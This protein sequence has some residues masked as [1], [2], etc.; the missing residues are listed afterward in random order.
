MMVAS[1]PPTRRPA[2][3]SERKTRSWAGEGEDRRFP[4]HRHFRPRASVR[5]LCR[6]QTA[7]KQTASRSRS[8]VDELQAREDWPDDTDACWH[9]HPSDCLLAATDS[10]SGEL[11]LAVADPKARLSDHR[12]SAASTPSPSSRP[13]RPTR[14]PMS[15]SLVWRATEW[16]LAF[17]PLTQQTALDYFIISPF[18]DRTSNNAVLRMQMQFSRGGMDGVDEE[19][20]LK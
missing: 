20:E 19:A 18:F 6:A 7:S 4:S 3:E 10:T 12:S 1:Q 14:A 15:T 2:P 11:V 5:T 9:E 8:R 13:G 17:G 16:L